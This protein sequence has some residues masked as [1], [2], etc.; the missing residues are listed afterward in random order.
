MGKRT[1]KKSRPFSL[2]KRWGFSQSLT[3]QRTDENLQLSLDI[4]EGL[5][6]HKSRSPSEPSNLITAG[7]KKNPEN[8]GIQVHQAQ[9]GG[10]E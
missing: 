1:L 9:G 4:R 8:L 2:L 10:M 3:T 6:F 7:E 5:L